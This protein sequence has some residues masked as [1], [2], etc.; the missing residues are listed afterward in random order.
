MKKQYEA[1]EI[2]E[3]G[4]LKELTQQSFNKVGR[5]SDMFGQVANSVVISSLV[6]P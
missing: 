2:R 6:G 4:S 5:G 3:L 1:P